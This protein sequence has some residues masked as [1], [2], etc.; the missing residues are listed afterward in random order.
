MQRPAYF[1]SE[2]TLYH[3]EYGSRAFMRGEQDP[4]GAWFDTPDCKAPVADEGAVKRL[5]VVESELEQAQKMLATRDH[6]LSV[7]AAAK[8]AVDAKV[9]DLEQRA[10]AAET[11]RDEAVAGWKV[12]T[13]AHAQATDYA[14]TLEARIAKFDADGD[15]ASGGSASSA[16]KDELLAQLET[17]GLK[18]D[19][20]KSVATL[21]ADLE[22]A[23]APAAA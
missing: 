23:T 21:R 11:A 15:N 2:T 1:A 6:D 10:I 13:A 12:E 17:L 16:E 22:A 14:R 5:A 20:R 18:P 7:L 4:G 9:H 8:G 3:P 19:K